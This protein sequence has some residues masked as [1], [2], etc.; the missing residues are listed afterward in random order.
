MSRIDV[1]SRGFRGEFLDH[2][3]LT[4]QVEAWAEAFPEFVRLESIGRTPEGREIWLLTLGQALEEP[5]PTAWV[6]GNMHAA[7]LA[8]SCVALAIAE[9]FLRVLLGEPVEGL[10]PSVAAALREVHL[11]CVPRISPDGAEAVLT[12]GRYV[13]SVP[14]DARANREHAHWVAGDVDGDGLALVM[15]VE[16][17]TGEFVESRREPGLLVPRRIDDEGPFYK[18]YPE[19]S[20][21]H[22]DGLRVPDPISLSD[23]EPDLNR[24]FPYH[25]APEPAQYGAGR[26]PLS[27]PESRAVAEAATARPQIFTWLN[28]HTFGGV[29][30]RPLGAAPDAKLA[31]FDRALFHQ[32]EEWAEEL[33]GYPTVSGFH[34]FLYEPEKPLHGDLSDFAYHLR[35]ALAWVCELWDVFEQVGLPRR[36]RF[37]DRYTRL[38]R[39]HLEALAAWDREHNGGS[40]LVPWRKVEHPQLGPVEVGGVD[41][42]FGIWNPPRARLAEICRAQSLLYLRVASLCPRVVFEGVRVE[43]LGGER[44]LVRGEVVNLGYL[45]TYGLESARELPWNEP[46]V[47]EVEGSGP[48]P[49]PGEARRSLGHLEGWGRGRWNP[50]AALYY[51]RSRGSVSR[52]PFQ[53]L[54]EGRGE[55]VLRARSCRIG[56]A[57][58]RLTV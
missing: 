49:A 33:T 16:D 44:F 3:A 17:P 50:E 57:E 4:S 39:E 2:G 9:D 29:L 13:R 7:E 5:R 19:G 8:G 31:P 22:F 32:L 21:V 48:K 26:Y 58:H 6:D 42:R 52:A 14:R 46:L 51:Q 47:L 11:V 15:R 55:L 37:V 45:P 40:M 10:A 41:P 28:L 27:E 35:G 38:D 56:R 54:V 12:S 20:I 34:E 23:N 53:V 36:E 18:L 24:N 43:A 30:I 1:L 25:W